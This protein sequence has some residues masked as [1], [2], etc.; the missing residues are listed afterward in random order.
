M[1]TQTD[2]SARNGRPGAFSDSD[3]VVLILT[4]GFILIFIGASIFNSEGVA[5][6][7]GA[8]GSVID[9]M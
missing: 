5:T 6:V 4:I 8:G 7:I 2:S 9:S 1:T 3:P